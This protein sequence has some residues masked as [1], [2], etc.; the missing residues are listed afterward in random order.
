MSLPAIRRAVQHL[1]E[2]WRLETASAQR[3]CLADLDDLLDE[4]DAMTADSTTDAELID[5][6]RNRIE[7]L[8]DEIDIHLGIEPPPIAGAADSDVDFHDDQDLSG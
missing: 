6:L 8:S 1:S 2:G 3:H 4:L 5:E 7:I